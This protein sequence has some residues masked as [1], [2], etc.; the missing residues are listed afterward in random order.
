VFYR[1]RWGAP[2]C[3]HAWLRAFEL[4]DCRPATVW[5]SR[6]T[7]AP[8]PAVAVRGPRVCTSRQAGVFL[9]GDDVRRRDA[10]SRAPGYQVAAPGGQG[11][12]ALASGT[13]VAR[14]R[15]RAPGVWPTV[16]RAAREAAATRWSCEGTPTLSSPSPHNLVAVS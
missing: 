10:P 8:E 11:E 2:P 12:V 5:C 4:Q 14:A 1:R 7:H 9:A 6:A 13:A 3:D 16:T 15:H